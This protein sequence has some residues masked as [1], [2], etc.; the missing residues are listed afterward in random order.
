M[1][2]CS[3][4]VISLLWAIGCGDTIPTD[5]QIETTAEYVQN[6]AVQFQTAD[7]FQLWGSLLKSNQQQQPRPVVILLHPF[8]QDHTEWFGFSPD[9]VV[10]R[11][12]VVLAFDLRGHGASTQQ[13][14]QSH[15]LSTF[16]VEELNNMPLDVAA[17]IA[18][19]KTRPDIDATRIGIVGADIGANVAFVASGT[20]SGIKTTVSISPQYR[21]NQASEVLIGTNIS[22][23]APKN[24]LYLATF[25]DGYAYTS[26]E[27]MSALTQG[28]T[29]VLGFQGVSHGLELVGTNNGAWHAVLN[30]LSEKL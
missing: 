16:T 30:W 27:S 1:R 6:E 8:N 28:E 19:V 20:V 22:D 23:F 26:A 14:G 17:A 11:G 24:I 15:P 13:N 3:L 7:G 9:L 5:S 21:E 2:H 10:N 29:Q 12:F 4:F 25:G 18:F